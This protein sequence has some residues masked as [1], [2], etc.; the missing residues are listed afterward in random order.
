ME[1]LRVAWDILSLGVTR[2]NNT[3]WVI[4][5]WNDEG[6]PKKQTGFPTL[7]VCPVFK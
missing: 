1:C 4:F 3:A 7:D 6:D 5:G 2:L